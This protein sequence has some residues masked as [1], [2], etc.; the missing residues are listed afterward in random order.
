MQA[1]YPVKQRVR[2]RTECCDGVKAGKIA[3]SVLCLVK[4]GKIAD[5]VLR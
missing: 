5:S 1:G 2:L 4:A 3:D